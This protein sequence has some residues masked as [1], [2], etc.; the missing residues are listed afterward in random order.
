MLYRCGWGRF[1]VL[2]VGSY[3]C[4]VSSN[5]IYINDLNSITEAQ[6]HRKNL[7]PQSY[8]KIVNIEDSLPPKLEKLCKAAEKILGVLFKDE[9]GAQSEIKCFEFLFYKNCCGNGR[10]VYHKSVGIFE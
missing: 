1:D 3:A 9:I 2:V 10:C 5:W 7:L 6:D 4:L 8:P